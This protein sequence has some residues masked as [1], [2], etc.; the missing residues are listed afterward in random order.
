MI[1]EEEWPIKDF[2]VELRHQADTCDF[3]DK[4]DQL[5]GSR[6]IIVIHDVD[7]LLLGFGHL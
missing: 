4:R 3:G 2:I 6:T 1:S 7:S 5:L